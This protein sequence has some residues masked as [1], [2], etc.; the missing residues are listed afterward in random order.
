MHGC[1][2]DSTSRKYGLFA[3]KPEHLQQRGMKRLSALTVI[4]S[5]TTVPLTGEWLEEFWCADCQETTWYHVRKLEDLQA[6]KGRY[7]YEL[8]PAPQ[9]LWQQVSGVIL[10]GGNPSVS[11]FT[12]KAARN[13]NYQG[14]R[15]FQL[16]G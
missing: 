7:R 10:P 12:R 15:G 3:D 4:K 5:Y 8:L 9:H 2:L 13:Q 14:L 6:Q 11:E 1:Y 16:T